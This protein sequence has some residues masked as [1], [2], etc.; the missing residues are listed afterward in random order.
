MGLLQSNR[1]LGKKWKFFAAA[2]ITF[3]RIFS[4]RR[5]KKYVVLFAFLV[6]I[7]RVALFYG[8]FT[9]VIMLDGQLLLV[10]ENQ[11][12]VSPLFPFLI[13]LAAQIKYC[14]T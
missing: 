8:T 12:S 1:I 14:P 11:F 10:R 13:F 2:K 3:L 7:S 6:K 5:L 4:D 9:H